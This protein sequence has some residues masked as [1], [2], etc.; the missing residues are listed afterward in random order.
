LAHAD[1]TKEQRD[2][3]K[4]LALRGRLSFKLH[5]NAAAEKDF[6][7]SM[8]LS[9]SAAAGEKLGEIAELNKDFAGAIREYARAFA[10]ADASGGGA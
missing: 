8:A 2:K 5:D 10:L 9:P 3:M 7:A 1:L 6:R 4:I